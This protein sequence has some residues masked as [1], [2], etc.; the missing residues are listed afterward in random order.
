MEKDRHGVKL[1]RP[2]SVLVSVQIQILR[3]LLYALQ[4]RF[5]PY[6]F[7]VFMTRLSQ[8]GERIRDSVE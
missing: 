6:C 5:R 2:F 1:C 8:F 7:R 3:L 4:Y